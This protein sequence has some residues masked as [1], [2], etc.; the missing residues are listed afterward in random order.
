MDVA[1][2]SAMSLA[3]DR[4]LGH[5]MRSSSH[6]TSQNTSIVSKDYASLLASEIARCEESI[7]VEVM[8]LSISKSITSLALP[9]SHSDDSASLSQKKRYSANA[10]VG[11]GDL[12]IKAA[13]HANEQLGELGDHLTVYGDKLSAIRRDVE[14]IQRKDGELSRAAAAGGAL[15]EYLRKLADATDNPRDNQAMVEL[16]EADTSDRDDDAKLVAAAEAVATLMLRLGGRDD[17][18]D[19]L[20]AAAASDDTPAPL[21]AV[22]RPIPSRLRCVVE[23]RRAVERVAFEAR[24]RIG[25]AALETATL[26]GRTALKTSAA[27]LRSILGSN[28]G[29]VQPWHDASAGEPAIRL[30]ALLTMLEP[31]RQPIRAA[32]FLHAAAYCLASPRDERASSSAGNTPTAASGSG[33]QSYEPGLARAMSAVI[34][35]AKQLL[36]QAAQAHLA[37]LKPAVVNAEVGLA[38]FKISQKL[39]TKEDGEDDLHLADDEAMTS[40]NAKSASARAVA[41][42]LAREVVRIFVTGISDV[43]IL[44]ASSCHAILN[45]FVPDSPF[46][47]AATTTGAG[48]SADLER[49]GSTTTES[50]TA[51][52]FARHEAVRVGFAQ[53]A[54]PSLLAEAKGVLESMAKLVADFDAL[55][56]APALSEIDKWIAALMHGH[57]AV[58]TPTDNESTKPHD[59][60][61]VVVRRTI[62]NSLTRSQRKM[63]R[64]VSSSRGLKAMRRTSLQS[65]N[66]TTFDATVC[67]ALADALLATARGTLLAR[68][69]RHVEKLRVKTDAEAQR[70]ASPDEMLK[71][72]RARR[73]AVTISLPRAVNRFRAAAIRV[74]RLCRPRHP[75]AAEEEDVDGDGDEM[76]RNFGDDPSWSS[77]TWHP[78]MLEVAAD[79]S[80]HALF[81]EL[82]RSALQAARHEAASYPLWTLRKPSK[83][84]P[85]PSSNRGGIASLACM[86]ASCE[87]TSTA[88]KNVPSPALATSSTSAERWAEDVQALGIGGVDGTEAE[89][90][91]LA[92]TRAKA[93]VPSTRQYRSL[94][95]SAHIVH[96]YAHDLALANATP[97]A[98]ARSPLRPAVD[99]ARASL[100]WSLDGYALALV[101]QT[102]FLPVVA[103]ARRLRSAYA[104]I[105]SLHEADGDDGDDDTHPPSSP[106]PSYDVRF[107]PHLSPSSVRASIAA[108]GGMSGALSGLQHAST[109]CTSHLGS[110][111]PGGSRELSGA[112]YRAVCSLILSSAESL[113][114]MIEECYAPYD[115][116][117]PPISLVP[118]AQELQLLFFTC[119]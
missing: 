40:Q 89:T 87:L 53:R 114:Q 91:K 81:G 88:S 80:T 22:L 68:L 9:S 2:R 102:R 49:E 33:G 84:M 78:S 100:V 97:T 32:A 55:V 118:S 109:Q 36:A 107:Y 50:S 35:T 104:S 17:S 108:L 113:E 10:A 5:W 1:V 86:F 57:D 16:A 45:L 103:L 47:A 65:L 116:V 62:R 3:E 74:V 99:E 26:A 14:E 93:L 66:L 61:S 90:T 85:A 27:K 76:P 43:V 70:M 48:A 28:V 94:A 111:A 21:E 110:S 92:T 101:A 106:P 59:G 12:S 82:A 42:E 6:T 58:D 15:L 7:A 29:A 73:G 56:A 23:R 30:G 54:L 4:K 60:H 46:T 24:K 96:A 69:D 83:V 64:S 20:Y 98:A 13:Q 75:P 71:R 105:V 31:M 41:D 119:E 38:Q 79:D 44:S 115:D 77:G 72:A 67:G 112:A 34:S 95:A 37:R 52:H 117:T 51:A 25:T 11:V 8:R 18:C 39:R 19:I 63:L